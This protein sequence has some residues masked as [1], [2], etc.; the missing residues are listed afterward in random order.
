MKEWP[1]T[2]ENSPKGHCF[3]YLWDPAGNL[4]G[5]KYCIFEVI[6]S[7]NRIFDSFWERDAEPSSQI[8][9]LQTFA[10][11]L[12]FCYRRFLDYDEGLKG[13]GRIQFLSDVLARL[14]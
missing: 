11:A 13:E 9:I 3:T 12:S 8:V 5:A 14:L 1:K 7:K 6:G 4:R 2:P 10:L